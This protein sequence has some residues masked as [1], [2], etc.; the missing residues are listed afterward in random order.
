MKTSCRV[1]LRRLV[2]DRVVINRGGPTR[3]HFVLALI[4]VAQVLVSDANAQR[5]RLFGATVEITGTVESFVLVPPRG[6]RTVVTDVPEL[7]GPSLGAPAFDGSATGGVARELTV[8]LPLGEAV[9]LTFA[10]PRVEEVRGGGAVQFVAF[11]PA[12]RLAGVPRVLLALPRP[13]GAANRDRVPWPALLLALCGGASVVVLARSVRS[14]ARIVALSVLFAAASVAAAAL[15]AAGPDR[16][17]TSDSIHADSIHAGAIGVEVTW[18]RGVL[19]WP[20]TSGVEPRGLA[21]V[22]TV[23]AALELEVRHFASGTR[24]APAPAAGAIDAGFLVL[25]PALRD[26]AAPTAVRRW[27][28]DS[29]GRWWEAG[30]AGAGAGAGAGSG[31]WTANRAP[32]A[33]WAAA[34]WPAGRSALVAATADGSRWW[35]VLDAPRPP[36]VPVDG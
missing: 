33:A 14:R 26:P 13:V 29:Q 18:V 19:E 9:D 16:I 35:R 5:Q 2:L 31:G 1:L 32:T 36:G 8:P 11:E 7:L 22:E 15:V 4:F 21:V 27:W 12:P 34:G 30:G 20:T 3:A 28:R 23:P 10:P 17:A 24:V 6:G 25:E